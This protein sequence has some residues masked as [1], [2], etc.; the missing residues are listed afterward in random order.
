MGSV[1]LDDE[2]ARVLKMRE[3]D[4]YTVE[5]DENGRLMV[6][7]PGVVFISL[8]EPQEPA[9]GIFLEHL[10]SHRTIEDCFHEAPVSLLIG[11]PAFAC[12]DI[13]PVIL[14]ATRSNQHGVFGPLSSQACH[15]A[16]ARRIRA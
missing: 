2:D 8:R 5:E 1:V 3:Q 11:L 7:A 14:L 9:F 15:Q 4:G 12:F 6:S 13:N 16:N 10:T